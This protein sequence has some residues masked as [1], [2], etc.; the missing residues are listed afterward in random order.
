MPTK[1]NIIACHGKS[2]W[3][4]KALEGL[5]IATFW[6]SQGGD[7]EGILTKARGS[8]SELGIHL[9]LTGATQLCLSMVCVSGLLK[10]SRMVLSL[11]ELKVPS[12]LWNA[13]VQMGLQKPNSITEQ[14]P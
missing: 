3:W 10:E 11:A 9:V 8:P 5:H 12:T 6:G 2:S 1:I 7:P 14:S 4:S 13:G